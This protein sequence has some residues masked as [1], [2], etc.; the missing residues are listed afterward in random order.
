M[1][2]AFAPFARVKAAPAEFCTW[3]VGLPVPDP[4][5]EGIVTTVAEATPLEA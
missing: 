1:K 5:A 4:D 2:L 3:P